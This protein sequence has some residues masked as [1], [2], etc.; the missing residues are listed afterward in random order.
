MCQT[1]TA[2]DDAGGHSTLTPEASALQ[3]TRCPKQ[4][5]L[6]K[7]LNSG[8]QEDFSEAH[9]PLQLECLLKAALEMVQKQC[10]YD[11]ER[12]KENIWLTHPQMGGLTASP[13]AR[14]AKQNCVL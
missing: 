5:L 9:L 2:A 13:L 12:A 3:G 7:T 4:K 1:E 8:F 11:A 10:S 6:I 14:L